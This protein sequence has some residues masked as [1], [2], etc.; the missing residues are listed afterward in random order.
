MGGWKEIVEYIYIYKS[1][2]SFYGCQLH[3]SKQCKTCAASTHDI[4]RFVFLGMAFQLG[5]AHMTIHII[6]L[7]T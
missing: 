4:N 7:V 6:L 2:F 1:S 3:L 5:W